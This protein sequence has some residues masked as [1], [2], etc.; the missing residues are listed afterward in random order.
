VI[1]RRSGTSRPQTES[2][3]GNRIAENLCRCPMLGLEGGGTAGTLVNLAEEGEREIHH[4]FASNGDAED[5]EKIPLG[6]E[7]EEHIRWRLYQ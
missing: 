6:E 3:P 7:R 4:S 1:C 2:E 5:A